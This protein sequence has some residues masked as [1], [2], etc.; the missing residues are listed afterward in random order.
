MI[1][2][3]CFL[4]IGIGFSTILVN[5]LRRG[6]L[7]FWAFPIEREKTPELFWMWFGT[8]GLVIAATLVWAVFAAQQGVGP[9]I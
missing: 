6:T 8:I 7:P 4:A 3:L 2:G 5:G 1:E 9:R